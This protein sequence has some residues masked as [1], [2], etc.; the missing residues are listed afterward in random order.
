MSVQGSENLRFSDLS[1]EPIDHLLSPIE[2]YENLPLLSLS[3]SV[4]PIPEFFNE[5]EDNVFVALNNCQNPVD[6]LTQQ[7]SA[8]IHLY[9][10]QFHGRPSLY[11]L[12]KV[13]KPSRFSQLISKIIPK[14]ISF[15]TSFKERSFKSSMNN[16]FFSLLFQI[17]NL[18]S[19]SKCIVLFTIGYKINTKWIYCCWR[20]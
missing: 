20:K 6:D 4:K 11:H 17:V 7:E 3:E 2:G 8:S 15:E 12:L 19:F 14:S 9:T 13:N 16:S 5:I 18:F 1:D 10:M